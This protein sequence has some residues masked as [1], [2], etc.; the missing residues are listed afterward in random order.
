MCALEIPGSPCTRPKMFDSAFRSPG[1]TRGCALARR[2][3][4]DCTLSITHISGA[5]RAGVSGIYEGPADLLPLPLGEGW[6]EGDGG[7]GS[8]ALDLSSR[9]PSPQPS[10]MYRPETWVTGVRGHG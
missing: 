4:P 9:K 1:E 7:G 5:V 8:E 6:G 10:P 3:T 2:H